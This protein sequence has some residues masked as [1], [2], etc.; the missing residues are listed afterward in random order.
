MLALPHAEGTYNPLRLQGSIGLGVQ[1]LSVGGGVGTV[2]GP[3]LVTGLSIIRSDLF[4]PELRAGFSY[5]SS[6]TI[7]DSE[8][9]ANFVWWRGELEVCPLRFALANTVYARPCASLHAG[10][11]VA[12]G[13]GTGTSTPPA[14]KLW[15]ELGTG[16]LF[17]WDI[18]GPLRLEAEVGLG[19]PWNRQT[20]EFLGPKQDIVYEPMVAMFEGR[21]GLAVHFP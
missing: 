5:A 8:G 10:A 12:T 9:S 16:A 20:F 3:S 21:I 14:T 18:V 15:G 17:E 11:I 1:V 7:R 13:H 6:A 2:F 4:A 19:F